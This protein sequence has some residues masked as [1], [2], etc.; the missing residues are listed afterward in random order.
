VTAPS[1]SAAGL[2]AKSAAPSRLSSRPPAPVRWPA[3]RRSAVPGWCRRVR[4]E[5]AAAGPPAATAWSP[6]RAGGVGGRVSVAESGAGGAPRT[7]SRNRPSS[8]R[9]GSP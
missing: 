6:H 8:R 7:G 4:R 1:G 5:P 9:A 3:C 2:V